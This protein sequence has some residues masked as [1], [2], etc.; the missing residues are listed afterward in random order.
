[1]S[2]LRQRLRATRSDRGAVA[3]LVAV[4]LASGMI[5]VLGA[6][7]IDTGQGYAERAELQNSADSAALAVARGCARGPAYCDASTLPTSVAGLHADANAK[8]TTTAVTVVCG[9]DPWGIL[10][11][12][13]APDPAARFSCGAATAGTNYAEVHTETRLNDGSHLL[14]PVFGRAALGSADNGMT[15]HACARTQWG[16]PAS[17]NGFALTISYCEWLRYVGGNESLPVYAAPPPTVPPA[18]AEVV[19]YFHDTNPNPTHCVA[20][21]SGFDVPGDF[22]STQTTGNTCYTNFNFD[23]VLGTTSYPAEPGSSLS[24]PCETSLQ[25][26][27]QSHAVTF[28]P[29]YDKI[30]GTGNGGINT[31]WSMSAFVVTG[32]Y[33]PEWSANSWLTGHKPCGGNARCVSGY[34]TT[35]VTTGGSIGTGNGAGANVVQLRD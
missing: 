10:P 30:V 18:S 16:K 29:I 17:A 19:L 5:F 12:C 15:V 9:H 28:V 4:V 3:A 20:G 31:L 6:L 33:W 23:P 32:Y 34:F 11:A 13:P 2:G 35:G 26:A 25:Q 21:P 27:Q 8:D 24:G 7:V 22:G 14:P 1:M